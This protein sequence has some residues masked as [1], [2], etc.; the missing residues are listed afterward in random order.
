MVNEGSVKGTRN[1]II[2]DSF[3]LNSAYLSVKRL[4]LSYERTLG[5]NANDLDIWILFFELSGYS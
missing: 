4:R 2:S 1:N 5:I 3:D